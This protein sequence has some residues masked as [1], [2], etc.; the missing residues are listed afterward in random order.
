MSIKH[1]LKKLIIVFL[2]I[3]MIQG[4]SEEFLEKPL[5]NDINTST[6]YQTEE[7]AKAAIIACYDVLAWYGSVAA[8]LQGW[9]YRMNYALTD[10][11]HPG[12]LNGPDPE[13]QPLFDYNLDASISRIWVRPWKGFYTLIMRS[14]TILTYLPD[15]SID[16]QVKSNVMAEAKFLRALS[17]FYLVR[18]WGDVP[19]I[20]YIPTDDN[21][22]PERAPVSEIYGLIIS[23]LED[24]IPVLPTEWSG[25]NLG[26]A[27]KG[28]A[29]TLLA[30]VYLTRGGF[31]LKSGT[32]EWEKTLDGPDSENWENALKWSQ[33]VIDL[34]EYSLW[35]D[36]DL[37]MISQAM[38]SDW[39]NGNKVE[40]GY[41]ANFWTEND[42]DVLDKESIFEVQYVSYWPNRW[43]TGNLTQEG[44]NSNAFDFTLASNVTHLGYNANHPRS[45]FVNSYAEGD[46]R[47]SATIL[48]PGDTLWLRQWKEGADEFYVHN[49]DLGRYPNIVGSEGYIVKKWLYG[50]TDERESS[51]VN[52]HVFRYAEVLLMKAEALNEMGR[53]EDAYEPLNKVR[54]RAGLPDLQ[55]G[56]SKEEFREA[57]FEERKIELAY[58]KKRWFDGVRSGMLMDWVLADRNVPIQRHHYLLPVPTEILDLNPNLTQNFGY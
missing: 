46:V 43:G 38:P 9:L 30:K 6:F 8:G 15:A 52:E 22:F 33:A 18:M 31:R 26:R 57:V 25:L 48:A 50:Y 16:E 17:Y 47:K 41:Q 35:Q 23:D 37:D 24:A 42:G 49:G 11:S 13:V 27:T 45:A 32:N 44:S 54:N 19:L 28:A 2:A 3:F 4:C 39:A 12:G 7:D 53:T 14:N 40:S 36:E 58:E 56:L 29:M 21:L 55:P 10:L 34:G 1:K 20:D 51:P 5:L